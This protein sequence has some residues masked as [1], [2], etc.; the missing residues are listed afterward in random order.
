MKISHLINQQLY[1]QEFGY[2][3]TKIPIGKSADFITA[4]EI[5]QIFGEVV[6][7][8]LLEIS[9]NF[10]HRIELVEMGAGRGFWFRDILKTIHFLAYKNIPLAQNF[11][12]KT[13]F[14]IIEINPQLINVQKQ[15]LADYNIVWHEC[16]DDFKNRSQGEIL[17]ISNELFDCFAIDQYIKTKEGWQ[18]RL[19]K[20]D[21]KKNLSNPHFL[22]RNFDKEIHDFVNNQI[23][24]SLSLTAPLGA[25]FEYSISARNFMN[26]LCELISK[27]GGFAL[28]IDYGYF[29]YDFCNT[30]QTVHNHQKI[31]FLEGLKNADITALVDFKAL[32]KIVKNHHLNSSLISQSQFLLS[33]GGVERLNQL[34]KN[35]PNYEQELRSGFQRLVADDQMGNLFKVHIIW[36]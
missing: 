11:I 5:S 21:N 12:D 6:A 7:G 28:N 25:I 24:E 19:I 22:I 13:K 31:P 16:F 4:P 18:E 26:Q 27:R 14:H 10:S 2:Y 30:L 34:I 32:D 17:F 36:R 9:R 8:Y 20:F 33:L 15:N 35:N 3:K 1:S 29:E 23:G